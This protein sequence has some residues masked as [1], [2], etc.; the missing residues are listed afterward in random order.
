MNLLDL[1][2]KMPVW[3]QNL[4][5]SIQGYRICKRRYNKDFYSEL[6][7]YENGY[8]NQAQELVKM[9][10]A[11]K[12]MDIYKPYLQD[13]NWQ[14]LEQNPENV[15]EIL[16]RFPII[17]KLDV[18]S[19]IK[20]YTNPNYDG[21]IITMRTSGTTGGGLIFPYSVEMEN[22]QW[23]VWWRYRR[24]LGIQ[25][26]TWCGW[27]GGRMIIP[28]TNQRPPFWRVNKPGK[29]I[30]YSPYHLSVKTVKYYYDD[31]KRRN[32]IWLH[33]YPSSISSLASMIAEISLPPVDSV[34][35][36]TTGAE[37]LLEHHINS[38]KRS[39]PNA[40]IRTHYGL[41]EG[42]ANF[43]QDKAAVWHVDNDFCYVE[44]V[45][46]NKNDPNVCRIIG[47]GFS[48]K[49]F[50]LVRY[51]TG[52]LAK[53]KWLNRKPEIV[54]IYGRQ[55]DYIELPNGVRLG[56]LDHI[57]KEFVNIREAQIHQLR[58][59]F[60]ELRVVKDVNYTKKDEEQLLFEASARF[61]KDVKVKIDYCNAIERTKAGKVKFVV[62]EMKN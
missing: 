50:P 43:S 62:S 20:A 6:E 54:E 34:R 28:L 10:D 2:A 22:R 21:K 51:D 46:V 49:V 16:S 18:K 60:I 13:V 29:Q 26:D 9:L 37:N 32:I 14:N 57:F 15:Y 55:E 33:G 25:F 8:Y 42:V 38:I 56:R 30:M 5:C 7:R 23:A 59:D 39:F 27:L 47:T 31:I 53:V 45:T 19:N 3:V 52:D 36:I 17:N 24:A 4:M 40:M 12:K 35:W 1:Y 11:A 41:A 61:G 44:F 58:K 48:N